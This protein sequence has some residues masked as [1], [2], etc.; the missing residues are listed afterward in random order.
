MS[1]PPTDLE[2]AFRIVMADPDLREELPGTGLELV[3]L[4]KEQIASLHESRDLPLK[5]RLH[6]LSRSTWQ[7]HRSLWRYLLPDE[8]DYLAWARSC[9]HE[10]TDV[11]H[12][13][14]RLPFLLDLGALIRDTAL[15]ISRLTGFTPTGR[16]FLFYGTG[17]DVG[18]SGFGDMWVNL[19][20]SGERGPEHLTLILP[21]ELNHQIMARRRVSEPRTLLTVIVEEGF[22][23]F[24]N[25]LYWEGRHTPA[26]SIDF[27]EGAWQWCLENETSLTREASRHLLSTDVETICDHHHVGR[28]PRPDAPDRLAYFLGFRMCQ[29]YV[30]RNGQDSWPQLYDQPAIETLRRSGYLPDPS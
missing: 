10:L 4:Y 19:L 9:W 11:T 30:E 22:C 23:C 16:W 5:E 29:A 8:E 7:P 13:G 2:E 20:L 26:E 25:H 14:F 1:R 28:R 12:P 17:C 18:G 6:H 15:K 21:H 27:T 24:V 3:H